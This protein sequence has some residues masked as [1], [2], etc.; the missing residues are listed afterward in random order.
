MLFACS[1][2]E[3]YG[4]IFDRR[5]FH[6]SIRH[7]GQVLYVVAG[8]SITTCL[9]DT[10]YFPFDSQA[11]YVELNRLDYV[12]ITELHA[13]SSVDHNHLQASFT[14]FSDTGPPIYRDPNAL[15]TQGSVIN[16]Y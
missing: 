1:A 9:L 15:E 6:V 16:L 8:K 12:E 3:A 2:D 11:C 4:A 13:G 10:T 5:K 7:D 14:G